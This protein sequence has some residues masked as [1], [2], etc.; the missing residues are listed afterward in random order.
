MNNGGKD[1]GRI[2]FLVLVIARAKRRISFDIP[3]L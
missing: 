1:E 3:G 2:L